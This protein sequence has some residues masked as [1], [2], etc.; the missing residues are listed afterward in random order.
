MA[1]KKSA[2]SKSAN[3]ADGED[4]GGK[5]GPPM[6]MIGL[7][8]GAV[9]L[10]CLTCGGGGLGAYLLWPAKGPAGLQGPGPQAAGGNKKGRDIVIVA[11]ANET[12]LADDPKWR[13]DPDLRTLLPGGRWFTESA[14]DSH[15]FLADGTMKKF[16]AGSS[17][18]QKGTY[19]ITGPETVEMT[20]NMDT[21]GKSFGPDESKTYTCLMN[22]DELAVLEKARGGK[23]NEYALVGKYYRIRPDGTGLG[24][25]KVLDP[26]LEKLKSKKQGD[27]DFACS[28]LAFLGPDAWPAVPD[29]IRLLEAEPTR[30]QPCRPLGWIGPKAKDAI[31]I[32][33]K[34]AASPDRVIADQAGIA[35]KGIQG[36]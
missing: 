13:A 17:G 2:S 1:K 18:K 4:E 7:A 22:D 29:L 31:P 34:R 30:T 32:L 6:L 24:R 19:R 36:N 27:R 11:P 26:L 5:K 33:Q 15:E 3:K 9:L 12:N 8:A 14:M 28:Q 16:G 35:L 21:P 10:L 23:P 20:L 25:T